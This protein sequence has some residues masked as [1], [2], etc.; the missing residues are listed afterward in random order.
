[1]PPTLSL[2]GI[3]IRAVE[4]NDLQSVLELNEGAV[5]HVNSVDIEQMHW[6]SENAHFFR[7]ALKDTEIVAFLV[8]LNQGT[9]YQ[10]PNYR[11]FCDHYISFIYVDRVVVAETAR[12]SGL[13][14]RLYD[15]FA[16]TAPDDARMMTC[17]VNIKP[18]N[19]TSMQFHLHQ[20]FR[21]VGSLT[22]EAGKKEVALM[23]R[24]L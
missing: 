9:S 1:M 3:I 22:T 4:T 19:D 13:A 17:E 20:G 7:V 18:A 11:W 24:K 5:P 6:F 14:T 23:E 12:Q 2:M 21:K 8:G 16:A 10:S 15:D